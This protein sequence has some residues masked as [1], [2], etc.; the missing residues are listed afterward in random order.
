MIKNNTTFYYKNISSDHYY[1]L[2]T[3]TQ[4][5]LF[6]NNFPTTDFIPKRFCFDL[7]NTLVSFPK[8]KRLFLCRSY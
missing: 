8:T 4:V 2:G 6:C 7:D 3:P 5:R 1:C